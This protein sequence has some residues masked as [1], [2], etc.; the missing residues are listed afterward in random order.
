MCPNVRYAMCR[1]RECKVVML[2]CKNRG[3]FVSPPYLD[4]YGETDQ[5]LRRGNPLHL[6]HERYTAQAQNST[7]F[8]IQQNGQVSFLNRSR[9]PYD[10]V[11]SLGVCFIVYQCWADPGCLSRIRIFSIPYPGSKRFPNPGFASAS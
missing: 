7:F 2:S 4:Q 11:Q 10:F 3:C 8:M 1:V 9:H 5:G 6:S